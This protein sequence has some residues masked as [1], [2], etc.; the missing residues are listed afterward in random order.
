MPRLEVVEDLYRL[1]QLEGAWASLADTLPSVTPFQ[2]P[3]WQLTWWHHFGSGELRVLAWW[4]DNLLVALVPCFL[5]HWEGRRQLTLIGSGLSDYLEPLI[6]PQR[7]ASILSQLKSYLQSSV[8]WDLC[9]WQDLDAGTPLR[10]LNG[11]LMEDAACSEVELTGDFEAFWQAR[12]KDMRRNLR[13]YTERARSIGPISFQAAMDFDEELLDALIRLHAARWEKRDEPGMIAANNAS[14]F[15]R[16][17]ARHFASHGM[18]RFFAIRFCGEIAALVLTFFYRGT[19]YSYMS[20]FDPE[21]ET[22]GFGRT[23]L[24]E[25]LQYSYA[26]G[27]RAWNFCRGEEHYKFSWGAQPIEK[28]RLILMRDIASSNPPSSAG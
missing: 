20:A 25:S 11:S 14:A 10:H 2:L 17:I 7:A 18:L 21:H 27:Y 1:Q 6:S 8:E 3:A 24:F 4:E 19:V 9:N 16:D 23:L 15:L 12:P 5:H 28:L 13:R 26:N 22:L